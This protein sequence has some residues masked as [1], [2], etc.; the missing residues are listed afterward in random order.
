[1]HFPDSRLKDGLPAS[2][3][4]AWAYHLFLFTYHSI[5][6]SKPKFRRRRSRW[7]S[8]ENKPHSRKRNSNVKEKKIQNDESLILNSKHYSLFFLPDEN[9]KDCDTRKSI[10]R[11]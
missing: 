2:Y 11:Q 6:Y 4:N 7:Q 9:T 8:E 1:M 3:I 10:E 5:L